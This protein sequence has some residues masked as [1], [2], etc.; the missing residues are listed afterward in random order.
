MPLRAIG[1]ASA[2]MEVASQKLNASAQNTANMATEGY[3]EVDSH[4]VEMRDGVRV[5]TRQ[6][7]EPGVDPVKAVIDRRFSATMYSANL[8]VVK[9]AD[10]MVGQ[11]TD[12]LA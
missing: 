6:K 10:E 12:L 5:H 9:V 8:A 7:S 2:G 11:T 4:G 3:Q 1:R